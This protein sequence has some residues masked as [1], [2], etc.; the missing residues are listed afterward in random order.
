MRQHLKLFALSLFALLSMSAAPVYAVPS[1]C[2]TAPAPKPPV[3]NDI[4]QD[5]T[6]NPKPAGCTQNPIIKVIA[7]AVN[8]ISLAIGFASIIMII[9]GGIKYIVSSGDQ[10]R[11]KSAKDTVMYAVIGV[12]ISLFAQIIVRF[13]LSKL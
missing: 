3:C 13:I 7:S 11:V 4:G 6:A 12:A 2:D 1:F 10:Q 8:V 9:I 5:C